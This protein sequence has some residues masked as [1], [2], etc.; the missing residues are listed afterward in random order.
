FVVVVKQSLPRPPQHGC[1]F[2]AFDMTAIPPPCDPSTLAQRTVGMAIGLFAAGIDP[3]RAIVFV[4][5]HVPEHT[6]LY[7]VLN[8]V[9]P[10]GELERQTAFKDKAQRQESVP[11][12]L[13]NYPVLQAA[14]VLL[15]EATLVPAV[16]D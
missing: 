1:Q 8:T 5:S 7:W 10:L 14:D 3:A 16:E 11:A 6:E 9:T 12:G 15:Y 4:Q 2:C 13:L